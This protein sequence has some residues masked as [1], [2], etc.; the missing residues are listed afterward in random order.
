MNAKYLITTVI[1]DYNEVERPIRV[2]ENYSK[3]ETDNCNV[4]EINSDG[5]IGKCVKG[6]ETYSDSGFALVNWTYEEDSGVVTFDDVELIEKISCKS[7]EE[8]VKTEQ[9]KRWKN[10]VKD[11]EYID[12]YKN[13]ILGTGSFC[14][15]YDDEKGHFYAIT[16]YHGNRLSYPF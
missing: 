1:E 5:T 11:S 2:C 14:E 8:F 10:Y 13:E 12:E 15:D 9:F 6:Y 16:E 3:E 4:Y 7:R